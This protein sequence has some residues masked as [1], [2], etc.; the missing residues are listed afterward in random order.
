[1]KKRFI[2]SALSIMTVIAAAI[3]VMLLSAAPLRAQLNPNSSGPGL[4]SRDRDLNTREQEIANM[5]RSTSS[6]AKRDQQM[7]IAEI[8]EDFD[9]LRA[10]D[11]EMKTTLASTSALDYK[12]IAGSSAEIKRRATRIK[13]NMV[14][15][16]AK[17]EKRQKMENPGDDL[18]PSLT[19]LEGLLNS[20]LTNPI[21]SDTGSVDPQLSSKAKR[22]LETLI[23][24][25]DKVRKSAEKMSKNAAKP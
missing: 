10:I 9:R 3:V 23:D 5:E 14:F 25:S 1:M 4:T 6:T 19:A 12:H 20:F 17:D 2:T 24:F 8:N 16:G 21:F 15:P 7:V 13:T 11:E 22:D 18:K